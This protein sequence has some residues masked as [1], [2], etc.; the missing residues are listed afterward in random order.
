MRLTVLNL[1]NLGNLVK[2]CL[3]NILQPRAY[4]REGRQLGSAWCGSSRWGVSR[5]TGICQL[6]T[7]HPSIATED[8]SPQKNTP[9]PEAALSVLTL[10]PPS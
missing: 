1:G 4:R 10:P 2:G 5:V 9:Y 7:P 8:P 3:S 6:K